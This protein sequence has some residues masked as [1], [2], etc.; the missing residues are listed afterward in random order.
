[1]HN[2]H[3]LET[4]CVRGRIPRPPRVMRASGLLADD[5]GLSQTLA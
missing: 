4:V 1:M 2:I 3:F 5:Q